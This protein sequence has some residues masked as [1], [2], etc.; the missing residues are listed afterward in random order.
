MAML[1]ITDHISKPLNLGLISLGIIVTAILWRIFYMQKLHP[2]AKFHGPWYATS[3]SIVSA[4]ISAL[5][6][7]PQWISHLEKKYGSKTF[8]KAHVTTKS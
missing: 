3:S 5:R 6:K 4:L 2:L 7:E 1:A 8:P